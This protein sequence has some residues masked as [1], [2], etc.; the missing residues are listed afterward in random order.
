MWLVFL[1]ELK[2]LL[3]DRKTMF[4]MIAL[5]IIVFPLIIGVVTYFSGK[6]I[7]DIES[8]VLTYSVVGEEFA[9]NL[10]SQLA[11]AKEFQRVDLKEETDLSQWVQNEN[12]DFVL[13]IPDNYGDNPLTNGQVVLQLYLNDAKLNMVEKRLSQIIDEIA[14]SNQSAAF[15][16]LSLTDVQQKALL[17]PIIINK[18]DVADQ[19]ENWG[20]KI[21]GIIPYL[22]FILCL[23]GSMIP[24]TDLG[25][26]E[27]ER[28]TLET[29]LISPIE[30]HKLVLGKFLTIAFAGVTSALVTVASMAVWGIVL[31]QGMAIAMVA[32]F[33][34]AIS[35]LDFLLMFLMLIP[36]AA[37]FA[38]VLLSLSI[39]ARSFKEAQGYMT[40]MVMFVIVPVI[41]AM[42]P[43]V[44]LKGGWAWV[45]LTNVAL[46][47]KE[48]IK[49]T[50]DYVQ[51]VAILGSTAAIAIAALGFCVYWFDKEKVLFR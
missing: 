41:L 20:A 28:G 47:I 17:D 16:Q 6:A 49:G 22:V 29:L 48:L 14:L 34:G 23:Q 44:E 21:G 27:K 4:F 24:A 7:K 3:R 18:V 10:V 51:L 37:I 1:K 8:K 19:R 15:T 30:R 32:D 33:M 9:P 50:M 13:V 39:Y 26:G 42:L 35:L 25:A 2:E 43:G 5:P 11:A 46:A 45:P 36:V 38:A 40:P 31:S 12:A